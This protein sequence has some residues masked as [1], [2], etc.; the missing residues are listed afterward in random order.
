MASLNLAG[1]TPELSDLLNNH[2]RNGTSRL[3]MSFTNHIGAGKSASYV[4]KI[5]WNSDDCD[6]S[7]LAGMACWLPGSL[8]FLEI[9][10]SIQPA[11]SVILLNVKH[12]HFITAYKV[13][14]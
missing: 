6:A 8:M 5:G 13:Y 4:Q 14:R 9:M 11:I 7:S 1:K 2:V 10:D 12:C 3:D